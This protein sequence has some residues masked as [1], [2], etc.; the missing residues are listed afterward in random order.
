[1]LFNSTEFLI[2]FGFVFTTYWFLPHK[3]QN[4]FLLACSYLFYGSWNWKFLSLI[5]ISTFVDYFC[6]IYV[7]ESREEKRKKQFL[8]ISLVANLGMLGFFKYY[9][10]FITEAS[11]LLSA[12]GLKTS[13]S[14]LNIILPVGISFYTFQTM[15][16][17]IDIYRRKLEPTKDFF[18]LALFVSFFPQLVAGPIER[19]LHLLPQISKQRNFEYDS[20]VTGLRLAAWGMFKKVIIADRIAAVPDTVFNNVHDYAG[21]PLIIATVFFAVQIYCDFSGY[22]DIARG[23]AKMLGFDITINF[24]LPYYSKNPV[25]FWE[26]WHI[27]L[28]KWFQDYLYFPLAMH[29]MRKTRGVFN[30]YKAH[31]YAMTLIGLWHGANWTFIIFGAYWGLVIIAYIKIKEYLNTNSK[32]IT[33]PLIKNIFMQSSSYGNMINM[34]IMFLFVCVGWIF[35]RANN[36]SDALYILT[37]AVTGTVKSVYEV[38]VLSGSIKNEIIGNGLGV[39]GFE[40]IVCLLLIGLMEVVHY[41][42]SRVDIGK[43]FTTKPIAVRWAVYYASIIIMIFYAPSAG[44]QFIYFQF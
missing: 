2:F 26:R 36:I 3:W 40:F 18:D 1:M 35:F 39:S 23:T 4:R 43:L 16:Y 34:T 9:N 42:Q 33:N 24:N 44:Q 17:T 25:E 10:F 7:H 21:I 14:T 38:T 29:Y 30:K 6:G 22:S 28:S 13:I 27:S 15:S 11:G 37:H 8:V 32:K 5:I 31:F 41:T 20:V 19:A 12:V